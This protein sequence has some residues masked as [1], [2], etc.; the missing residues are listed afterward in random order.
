AQAREKDVIAGLHDHSGAATATKT[1]TPTATATK[2][3][4]TAVAPDDRIARVFISAILN[5]IPKL[6]R[7]RAAFENPGPNAPGVP[8]GF[9]QQLSSLAREAETGKTPCCFAK[10]GRRAR[11]GIG[12]RHRL[13]A[14]RH[15][16][17]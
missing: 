13:I 14:G 5:A 6:A 7:L 11:T 17:F 8:V 15:F 16:V 4:R 9:A 12:D 1:A 10:L 2:A 3:A